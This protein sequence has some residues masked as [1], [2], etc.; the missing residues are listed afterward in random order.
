MRV[1]VLGTGIMGAPMARNLAAAGHEVTAWNRSAKKAEGI[2]GVTAAGSVAEAVREAEVVITMLA[3]ADAVEAV[4][5]DAPPA[6]GRGRLIPTSTIGTAGTG[7]APRPG[8]RA[9]G[10]P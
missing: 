10:G 8:A 9:G 5:R 4:V 6:L 7:R 1:A 3:D 2:E